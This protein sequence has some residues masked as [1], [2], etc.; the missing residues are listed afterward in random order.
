MI[1]STHSKGPLIRFVTTAWAGIVFDTL[2]LKKMGMKEMLKLH[3]REE[4]DKIHINEI[5]EVQAWCELFDV[6]VADLRNA[7][8]VVGTSAMKVQNYLKEHNKPRRR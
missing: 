6:T 2:L 7:I 4:I 1:Y 3:D 5:Y 8:A